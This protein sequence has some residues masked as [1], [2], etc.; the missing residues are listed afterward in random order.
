VASFNVARSDAA[1]IVIFNHKGGVG[2]TTLAV[3]IAVALGNRGNRVLLVD[4]DPQCNM[5]SYIL[6][7]ELVDELLDA[8]DSANGETIWSA[9]KPIVDGD[10]KPKI[11]EPL[12]VF[13][14]VWLLPGDIR[15]SEFEEDLEE[16]WKLCYQKK[17]RGFRGVSAISLLINELVNKF[18]IDYVLYDAG[19]NIGPLNR[20]VVLDSDF[21]IIPAACDLFSIRALK[22]LGRTLVKWISEWSDYLN[23]MEALDRYVLPGQPRLLGYIAQRFRIYRG[24]PTSGYAQYIPRIEKGIHADVVVPLKR[25]NST[26]ASGSI[27]QLR[28]GLIKDFGTMATDSQTQGVPISDV[29]GANTYQKDEAHSTFDG[30][31][32]RLEQRVKALT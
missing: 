3:N 10:G 28:L 15:L 27:S 24:Q 20:V 31:A 12:S 26:L 5:T 9:M 8:S 7:D 1:R 2:K 14:N 23:R 17:A 6:S 4:S 16:F 25:L 30:L 18:A 19:P 21:L 13:E 32:K 11:V 29:I 22:T